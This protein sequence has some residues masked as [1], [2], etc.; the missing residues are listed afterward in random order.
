MELG[1]EISLQ[2]TGGVQMKRGPALLE[3][4]R[5]KLPPR[6][7]FIGKARPGHTEDELS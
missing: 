2:R 5:K 1:L 7:D 3:L 4:D 6:D